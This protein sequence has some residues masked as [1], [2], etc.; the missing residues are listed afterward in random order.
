[1]LRK[2]KI[3]SWID[4]NIGTL[5]LSLFNGLSELIM[6]EIAKCSVY[7]VFNRTV[8]QLPSLKELWLY[9]NQISHI[10]TERWILPK[11]QTLDLTNNQLTRL[12]RVNHLYNLQSLFLEHN[13]ISNINRA[14]LSKITN[15]SFLY[16][17]NNHIM[18]LDS[19]GSVYF[20]YLIVLNLNQN[21]LS[22]LNV[23]KWK[24]PR[25]TVLCV[26][27]N[28]LRTIEGLETIADGLESF[29]FIGN[30]WDREWVHFGM[31]DF[32]MNLQKEW[33][34]ICKI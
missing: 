5:D 12:P 9:D 8:V 33:A 16:L 19:L 18:N 14:D 11:L 25:L 27:Y 21:R 15:L 31:V 24:M 6:I 28:Q 13:L 26:E 30:P 7:E 17:A 22:R 4:N 1:M 32:K 20:P 23:R 10:E 34:K 29:C 3:I 2:L